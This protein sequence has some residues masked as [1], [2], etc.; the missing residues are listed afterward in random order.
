METERRSRWD[1]SIRHDEHGKPVPFIF[2]EG[3][4]EICKLLA[5]NQGVRPTWSY[6]YLPNSYIPALLKRSRKN[7]SRRLQ[8]GACEP[9][10]YFAQPD[11]PRVNF[12]D[13]IFS[14][15]KN[16]RDELRS[17]GF[18]ISPRPLRPIAHE[19]MAC[20]TGSSFEYGSMRKQGVKIEPVQEKHDFYPDWPVFWLT[21]PHQ[22][23]KVFQEVDRGTEQFEAHPSNTTIDDKIEQYLDLG[24]ALK[25]DAV[26]LF[27]TTRASRAE[28]FIERVKKVIDEKGVPHA[29]ARGFAATHMPYDR[30]LEK[31]PPLSPWALT[32]DYLRAGNI[33]TFNFLKS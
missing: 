15:G 22:Q 10:N 25:K 16:G 26:V 7:V 11:Q 4:L 17:E 3:D 13:I 8:E 31:I 32:A 12:R 24:D 19:L 5:P 30:F 2:N 18:K 6:Q 33:G 29:Y 9:H 1:T 21:T 23:K 14:I 28:K 27:T 20:I